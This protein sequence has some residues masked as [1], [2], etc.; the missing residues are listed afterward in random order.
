MQPLMC[1]LKLTCPD[2]EAL[3]LRGLG[4]GL[5]PGKVLWI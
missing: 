1:G 3:G 5:G 2:L 4:L